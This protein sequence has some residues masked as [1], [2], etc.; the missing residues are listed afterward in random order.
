MGRRGKSVL[1]VF[2]DLITVIILF[3]KNNSLHVKE[4]KK[5]RI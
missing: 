5:Y 1:L 4:I 3:I 2:V